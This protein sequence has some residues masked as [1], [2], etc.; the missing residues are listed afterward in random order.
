[1]IWWYDLE[2]M[3]NRNDPS[4]LPEE[5]PEQHQDFDEYANDLWVPY[6][7]EAKSHDEVQI[8]TLKGDVD[9]VL[10]FVCAMY[11]PHCQD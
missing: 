10:I 4:S 9:G 3:S 8:E 5:P 2:D 7:K 6:G 11:F 1:M